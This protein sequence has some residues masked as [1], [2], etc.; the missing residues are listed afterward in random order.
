[1]IFLGQVYEC[2]R[3]FRRSKKVVSKKTTAFSLFLYSPI[4]F[5][6]LGVV[7][8][9]PFRIYTYIWGATL[10]MEL[11]VMSRET[12]DHPEIRLNLYAS[13]RDVRCR[14]VYF[15]SKR[16]AGFRKI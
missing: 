13:S 16:R 12:K 5:H 3:L 1:M 4:A 7:G 6:L 10:V 9:R 8:A 14:R 11:R 2:G 15:I